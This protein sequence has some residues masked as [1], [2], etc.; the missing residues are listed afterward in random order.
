MELISNHAKQIMES[1]KAKARAAGLKFSDETMEYIVT[2]R[3]LIWLSAKNN[4]PTLYDYWLDDVGVIKD[5]T[6]YKFYPNNPYETV[7]NS[8]PPLSYYNDNNPDWLNVMLFYH[9]LGHIDFLQ[10]NRYFEETRNDDFVGQALADKRLIAELRQEQGQESRWVDYVIEF[11]RGIDNLVGFYS[12]LN[13]NDLP[14]MNQEQEKVDFY[15]G[16]FL[17]EFAQAKSRDYDEEVARHNQCIREFGQTTGISVFFEDSKKKYPEFAK[18]FEKRTREKKTKPND[19][20]QFLMENSP[21]INQGKNNWM[22]KVMQV[23][24]STSLYFQPQIRTKILNEGWASFW[25]DKLFMEDDRITGHGADYAKL[26]AGVVSMSHIGLNPYAL[27][28]KLIDCLYELAA[29]GKLNY[30]FEKIKDQH[31]RKQFDQQ[32]GRGLDYLFFIR[33]NFN[34]STLINFLSDEDFQD[35]VAKNQLFVMGTRLNPDT[36]RQEHYIKSRRATDY[37]QMINNHLY[38]PPHI[39]FEKA[40]EALCLTHHFEGKPLLAKHIPNTMLG[41][42]YLWGGPVVLE[43]TEIVLTDADD[44]DDLPP[45][46]R[47]L[48]GE[49]SDCWKQQRV[50]YTMEKRKLSKKIIKEASPQNTG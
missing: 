17:G 44:D 32:T 13:K 45:Q 25:H 29:K 2:N 27:G 49:D 31:Q 5:K 23:V 41:I 6:V 46:Y 20:L 37:R 4:V 8:R 24:R 34:D 43:T 14:T 35:F 22:K 30:N 9:V 36:K 10:N 12:E 39:T 47:Q 18:I 3:D 16:G 40:E 50:R 48:Y 15:F 38:H 33:E 26:N 28:L 1:C 11:S 21:V 42:E 7:I 19:L